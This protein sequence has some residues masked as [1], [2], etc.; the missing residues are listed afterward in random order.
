MQSSATQSNNRVVATLRH[1]LLLMVIVVAYLAIS[2]IMSGLFSTGGASQ[3]IGNLA[4]ASAQ[5]VPM[6]VFMVLAWRLVYHT[7]IL[8]S[9][10][11]MSR[12]KEEVR[13]FVSNRERVAVSLFTVLLMIAVLVAFANL[14]ALIPTIHPFSWDR[15]FM[16]LDKAL[17]FGVH[18]YQIVHSV[19]GGH[20]SLTFITGAYNFWLFALYFMLFVT[21]FLH[22]SSVARMQYLIAFIF[23]LAIGGSLFATVFS[24]VGPVYYSL[25]GLGDSFDPLMQRLTDHAA[26]GAL[27]ATGTHALLWNFASANPGLNPITAFPSMHVAT[28][29]LMAIYAFRLSRWLGIAMSVFAGIIMIG[30][31]LLAWHYAVDGYAGAII[32]LLSWKASGWLIRSPIGPF[33]GAPK[34]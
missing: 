32:A 3:K 34:A 22:W 13:A 16:E 10:D 18:P 27:T 12:I 30:S 33:A 9:E 17:H 1:H 2:L 26:T 5:N 15:T 21:C 11:R 7:Y 28:S 20:Y 14:K 19:F 24:S 29:V 8:K 31:V 4:M 25:L 6:M 23:T